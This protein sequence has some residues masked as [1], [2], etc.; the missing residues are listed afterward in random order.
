MM[1]NIWSLQGLMLAL[2]LSASCSRTG[3]QSVRCDDDSDCNSAQVCENNV[4]TEMDGVSRASRQKFR[5]QVVNENNECVQCVVNED[6]D[7]G[8]P[9]NG[10]ESCQEET[11]VPSTDPCLLTRARH[12]SACR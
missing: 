1:I 4:C 7:D 5:P 10:M 11:C 8:N 9:C 12:L 2:L 6:C 3:A